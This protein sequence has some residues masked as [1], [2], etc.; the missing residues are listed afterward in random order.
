MREF[1]FD[2][3]ERTVWSRWYSLGR[4]NVNAKMSMTRYLNSTEKEDE[5]EE[6][7]EIDKKA[8]KS[9]VLIYVEVVT[10]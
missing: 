6:T 4:L 1:S 2:L 5:I 10:K 9:E 8:T 3:W 7:E